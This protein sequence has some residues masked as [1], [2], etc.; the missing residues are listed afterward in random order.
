M[1]KSEIFFNVYMNTYMHTKWKAPQQDQ[2][3]D[4]SDS[5]A[6]S[7]HPTLRNNMA[8]PIPLHTDFASTP[9]II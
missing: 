6:K 2:N 4:Y 9:N 8:F 3:K 5:G 1:K 7:A